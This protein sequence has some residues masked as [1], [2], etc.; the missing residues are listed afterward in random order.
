MKK[1]TIILSALT[2]M[3]CSEGIIYAEAGD[4]KPVEMERTE[5]SVEGKESYNENVSSFTNE[6]KDE[7]TE[8]NR[9]HEVAHERSEER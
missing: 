2:M 7:E 8:W 5:M 3:L 9:A 1:A 6:V 4:A